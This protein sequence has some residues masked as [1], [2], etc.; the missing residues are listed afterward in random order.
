MSGNHRPTI[1]ID[2]TGQVFGRLTVIR[3]VETHPTKGNMWECRCECGNTY[4][5]YTGALRATQT[6]SC[7]CLMRDS[8]AERRTIHGHSSNRGVRSRTYRIWLSMTNRCRNPKDIS[9]KYYGG[10]GIEVCQRWHDYRNFL[11][12][13][14][15]IPA[16]LSIDR[17]DNEGNY[18]PGNCRTATPK[19]QMANTR[20]RKRM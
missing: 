2:L 14:G 18:E 10:R 12:D 1:R 9:Y 6:R 15:E 4:T 20:K 17:I 16:P 8:A 13:M 5:T 11:A 19:E 7:G 3:F